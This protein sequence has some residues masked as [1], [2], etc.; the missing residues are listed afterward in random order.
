LELGE[1]TCDEQ[2]LWLK[3]RLHWIGQLLAH[4][5]SKKIGKGNVPDPGPFPSR[6]GEEVVVTLPDWSPYYA[7]P[8]MDGYSIPRKGLT[9]RT[10]F[11]VLGEEIEPYG[12][13]IQYKDKAFVQGKVSWFGG[14]KDRSMAG[15]E[16][17][18]LTL[19]LAR[20]LS[21]DDYYAAMRWDYRGRKAFW[22]NRHLLVI[23]PANDRAVIVRAIDWGPNTFT[24]RI[25]DLSPK[26]LK[27]LKAK[28]DGQL[29]CSFS[30]TET[31]T[32]SV[33][34]V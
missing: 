27:Y 32:H 6:S 21:E 25:L 17:V 33:G 10:L 20:N 22:V 14:P 19:E 30:N 24:K 26:T 8:D 23:N 3:P 4:F 16:T 11:K 29:I 34:P 28:T 2:A 9:N 5:L 31:N 13:I 1:I 7:G 18:A 12:E 15:D